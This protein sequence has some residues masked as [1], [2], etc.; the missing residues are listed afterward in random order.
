MGTDLTLIHMGDLHG[1]LVPRPHLRSDG[2]GG[3]E[4]GLARI[5]CSGPTTPDRPATSTR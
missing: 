2:T 1:H 4:G 3:T 5:D